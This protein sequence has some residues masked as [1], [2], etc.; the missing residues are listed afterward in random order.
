MDDLLD[1]YNR[2][3]WRIGMALRSQCHGDPR[4]LHHTAHVVVFHP[5]G[6]RILLQKR[7]M[8]KDIQPGKWDTAVGGHLVLGEDYLEGAKRELA[9]E[10]GYAGDA[11]LDVLFDMQLRNDI[12]SEDIRVFGVKLG[13]PF[14]FQREEIDEV[15]FWSAKSLFEPGNQALFTPNLVREL[16]LLREHHLI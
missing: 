16:E 2:H 13:G 3:G 8:E 4:L 15:R 9:E 12:E 14:S 1:I 10:L 5:D 11:E 6:G 7:S